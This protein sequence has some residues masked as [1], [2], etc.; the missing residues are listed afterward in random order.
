MNLRIKEIRKEFRLN[1]EDFADRLGIGKTAISKI[2]LGI[3]NPSEQ[4]IK[5]ICQQF[6]VNEDWLRN[7]NGEMLNKLN[8]DEE[9]TIWSSKI[10]RNDYDVPF[11]KEFVH[12]LTRLDVEDWKTLEKI[13]KMLYKEKDQA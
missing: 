8:R 7:G 11:A 10:T 2:E 5:L 6:N 13:T 3:N 9:I 4:T 12:M 1:Q